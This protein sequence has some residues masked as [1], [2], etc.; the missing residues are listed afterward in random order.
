MAI[1][2]RRSPLFTHNVTS[3]SPGRELTLDPPKR[4][5]VQGRNAPSG[6]S[7]SRN[8]FGSRAGASTGSICPVCAIT[9]G[10]CG[11]AAATGLLRGAVVFPEAIATVTWRA[12]AAVGAAWAGFPSSAA[13]AA[14]SSSARRLFSAA[15]CALRK[16]TIKACSS[17]TSFI[18]SAEAGASCSAPVCGAMAP[19][20]W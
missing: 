14:F 8:D 11:A 6:R 4:S 20:N 15:S 19:P 2:C 16:S 1:F 10:A 17:R 7:S 9:S 12:A 3:G 13:C 18:I 5:P